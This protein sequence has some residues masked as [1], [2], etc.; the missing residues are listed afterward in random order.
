MKRA[1]AVI[2]AI[3]DMTQEIAEVEQKLRALRERR[4]QAQASLKKAIALDAA[5]S[6]ADAVWLP[7]EPWNAGHRAHRWVI[8]NVTDK[9]IDIRI[10]DGYDTVTY[11]RNTGKI[12]GTRSPY[13]SILDVKACVTAFNRALASISEQRTEPSS[14]TSTAPKETP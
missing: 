4:F 6:L 7:G 8:V 12:K 11:S 9:T 13:Q 10:D 3:R 2:D 5:D 14:E 1:P